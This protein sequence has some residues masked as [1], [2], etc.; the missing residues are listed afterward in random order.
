MKESGWSSGRDVSRMLEFLYHMG[1]VAVAG[2]NG[3]Q[4]VWDLS[5]R[6]LP[7][8]T[9][10]EEL[11]DD[12][13]EYAGSQLSLKGLGA[14]TPKEIA[15]HFL[16]GRYPNMK[17]TIAALVA[18]GKIVPAVVD[19]PGFRGRYF[20]HADD[21]QA[22]EKIAGGEW[23]PR[24]TILS[25]FDNLIADRERA[26]ALF[27]FFYRVEIYTPKEKRR[28]GF[29]VLPIL[30][31]D[32]LVGRI[33]PVM[34]RTTGTLRIKAVFAEKGAPAGREPSRR[35]AG[36]IEDLGLF[37]GAERGEYPG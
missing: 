3:R 22:A 37:L 23:E 14:A 9:P 13:V 25:P 27:E 8:W 18:E 28:A 15:G 36:A 6:F 2:R 19:A 30:D 4:K 1:V 24:T 32:R 26:L 31:G 17:K 33:D 20:L 16:I 29:Y 7:K 12:E 21:V 10:M 34:D 35:I 5:E 11:T